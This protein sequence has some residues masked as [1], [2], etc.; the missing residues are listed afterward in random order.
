MFLP[1]QGP[2]RSRLSAVSARV[3]SF[4]ELPADR[5]LFLGAVET[6]KTPT[7]FPSSQCS[8]SLPPT[9]SWVFLLPSFLAWGFTGLGQ[10][11]LNA[12]L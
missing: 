2:P 8:S 10:W 11:G 9:V 7:P 1:V 12:Y 3:P 4:A 5:L 6:S